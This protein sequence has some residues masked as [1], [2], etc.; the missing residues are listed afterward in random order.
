MTSTLR[1]LNDKG[2]DVFEAAIRDEIAGRPSIDFVQL[3]NHDGYTE[4]IGSTISLDPHKLFS[5]RYD[6]GVYL[7]SNLDLS[8]ITPFMHDRGFWTWL[9]LLYYGQL[10]PAGKKPSKPYNYVQSSDYR[11]RPR[12]AVFITWSLVSSYGD[13][14]SYLLSKP[15]HVRGELIEQL[16]AQQ[17]I[18]TFKGI[19]E[20]S[21]EL[22]TDDAGEGFKKGSTSRTKKGAI[23]RFI[24]WVD[25]ISINYDVYQ[26]TKDELSDLLPLEFDE[27]R[28]KKRGL[29]R[30]LIGL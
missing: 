17:Q 4:S 19:M 7:A 8:T 2:I 21:S 28:S 1:R 13:K 6:F 11:H 23:I 12:H 30:K 29:L 25:Q 26:M 10:K 14:S 24:N 20:L 22:Y 3:L 18:L 5:T 27:F 9:A 16:M 15:M